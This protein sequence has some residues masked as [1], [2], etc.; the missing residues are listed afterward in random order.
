MTLVGRAVSG[1]PKIQING[2]SKVT[3]A[4]ENGPDFW[5]TESFD[6]G[7]MMGEKGF[8]VKLQGITHLNDVIIFMQGKLTKA[9]VS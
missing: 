8:E 7:E 4:V 6:A 1:T 3:S 9:K 5:V 2:E